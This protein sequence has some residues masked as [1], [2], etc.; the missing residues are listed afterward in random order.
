LERDMSPG[1]VF[2][3]KD[4]TYHIVHKGSNGQA[5]FFADEDYRLYLSCLKAVALNNSCEI[6][7]YVLMPHYV[8]LLATGHRLG[9]VARMMAGISR[10]HAQHVNYA[11]GHTGSVWEQR[12][13]RSPVLHEASVLKCYRFIE[14]HPVRM[15][16]ADLPD[17]YPW[18]SFLINGA[19]FYSDVI[20]EHPC[21]RALGEEQA[22]RQAAYRKLCSQ[23][24]GDSD[25]EA[26]KDA[27]IQ[28]RAITTRSHAAPTDTLV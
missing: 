12:Y 11:Y 18:S 7:A 1:S 10:R 19:G 22:T 27:L 6:H 26:I 2:D 23:D 25:L 21:F 16:R 4:A 17:Q 3:L 24:L 5:C 8:Q 28:G 13:R 14:L 20:V 9:A 15:G